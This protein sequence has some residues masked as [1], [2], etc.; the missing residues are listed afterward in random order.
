MHVNTIYI[1]PTHSHPIQDNISKVKQSLLKFI[2][3]LLSKALQFLSYVPETITT[4]YIYL[5]VI[6]FLTMY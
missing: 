4:S 2:Y 1:F 5:L 6:Q 3:L